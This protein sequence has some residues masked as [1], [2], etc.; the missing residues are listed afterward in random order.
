MWAHARPADIWH[1]FCI[2]TMPDNTGPD[3][4]LD[5]GGLAGWNWVWVSPASSH[6]LQISRY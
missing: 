5:Q 1:Q 4:G 2:L 3:L 6:F